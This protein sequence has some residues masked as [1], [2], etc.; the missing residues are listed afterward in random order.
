V[1]TL[2]R[3][4]DF[5][6]SLRY[7]RADLSEAENRA[8]FGRHASQHG[9]N[10]R[11]EV[12]VRGEPDPVSGMVMDLKD[13]KA[14]IEREVMAR[15]DHRDLN[16]DTSWFEKEPRRPS[17]RARDRPACAPGCPV[18]SRSA[19][20]G[21]QLERRDGERVIALTRCYRFPAAHVLAIPTASD[22]ENRRIYGKCANPAGHGHDYAGGHL[23][24][25]DS[26]RAASISAPRSPAEPRGPGH[27]RCSTTPA[28]GARAHAE[29][30][31]R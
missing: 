26:E 7:W 18:S 29:N 28:S 31:A 23:K 14:V 17:I 24:G 16:R 15:F 25:P 2:T 11:L 6:A 30:I 20:E 21:R 1:V 8:L 3:A 10:Y 13:L 4:A 19:S 22:A 12:S 27:P 9:H 5:S